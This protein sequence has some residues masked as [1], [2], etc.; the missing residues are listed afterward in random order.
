LIPFNFSLPKPLPATFQTNASQHAAPESDAPSS[1][2]AVRSSPVAEN[3]L[4]V[5]ASVSS[6]EQS[7]YQRSSNL[8]LTSF[9]SAAPSVDSRKLSAPQQGPGA[10]SIYGNWSQQQP[11]SQISQSSESPWGNPASFDKV[12]T[13]S[14]SAASTIQQEQCFTP[15]ST[16]TSQGSTSNY[17]SQQVQT[18]GSPNSQQHMYSGGRFASSAGA[19]SLY[20]NLGDDCR[21]LLDT[22]DRDRTLRSQQQQ[23]QQQKSL[24]SATATGSTSVRHQIKVS[25][26]GSRQDDSANYSLTS[27]NESAENTRLVGQTSR[28]ID[29]SEYATSVV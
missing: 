10:G 8:K 20:G 21:T 15:T 5:R 13:A 6:R 18:P 19:A 9:N 25:T 23:Q 28:T 11:A 12:Q 14:S 29:S 3:R 17:S 16:L 1:V 26:G 2:L 4:G 27:S 7:P 22:P 24:R